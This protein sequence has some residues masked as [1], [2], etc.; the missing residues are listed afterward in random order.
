MKIYEWCFSR[1]KKE[2]PAVFKAG[3]REKGDDYWV[4]SVGVSSIGMMDVAL[5]SR[6]A[7]HP[8]S[9]GKDF[10]HVP[11]AGSFTSATHSFPVWESYI[12]KVI[13]DP[14]GMSPWMESLVFSPYCPATMT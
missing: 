13:G 5:R 12:V 9:N 6:T 3:E 7:T 4:D 11:E 8:G 1:K 14:D 2:F 10:I